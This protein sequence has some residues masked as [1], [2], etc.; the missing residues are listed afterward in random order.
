MHGLETILRLNGQDPKCTSMEGR[1]EQ[2]EY[3]RVY[4]PASELHD[5]ESSTDEIEEKVELDVYEFAV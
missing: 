1:F 2:R 3:G 5:S 4:I